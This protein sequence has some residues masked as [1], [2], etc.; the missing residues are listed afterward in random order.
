M[1]TEEKLAEANKRL[2]AADTALKKW[3][4]HLPGNNSA[5]WEL[6]EAVRQAI[7]ATPEV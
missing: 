6:A 2:K 4:Q 1:T 7:T 5:G 3:V